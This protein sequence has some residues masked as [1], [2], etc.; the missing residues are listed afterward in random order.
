MPPFSL[1]TGRYCVQNVIV[2]IVPIYFTLLL[3]FDLGFEL[4]VKHLPEFI[5]FTWRSRISYIV[6]F[7]KLML[8]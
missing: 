8:P 2:A 6:P 1:V 4:D 5:S 7:S 3:Y